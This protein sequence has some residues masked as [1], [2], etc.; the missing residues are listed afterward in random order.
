MPPLK[1][2]GVFYFLLF[3]VICD[4]SIIANCIG[5]PIRYIIHITLAL[6]S[7][8]KKTDVSTV[9]TIQDIIR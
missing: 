2:R 5:I 1:S 9:Q 6:L 4:H 7:I 3:L 8:L